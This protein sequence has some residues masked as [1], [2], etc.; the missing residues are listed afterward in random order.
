[1]NGYPMKTLILKWLIPSTL[2][3]ALL[4]ISASPCGA[5]II[6]QKG[7][8]DAPIRGYLVSEDANRIIVNQVLPDGRLRRVIL[9]R[10][11]IDETL[12]IVSVDP[13]RLARL[14]ADD[15]AGYRDYAEV[16]S[17]RR[18]DPD[19]Q[20]SAIRLY[21]IAAYLSPEKLGRGSLLGMARLARTPHEER[22]F[23]AFAYLLDPN[24][25][26][27]AMTEPEAVTPAADTAPHAEQRDRLL[28]GLRTLRGGRKAAA[29]N[30]ASAPLFRQ[31]LERYQGYIS[32]DEFLAEARKSNPAISASLLKRLV[33]LEL[34]LLQAE[35]NGRTPRSTTG[36]WSQI[37]A[38]QL[39]Q[40]VLPLTL[41][42]ITEFDPRK[43]MYQDGK[44][45]EP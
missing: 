35:P 24:H 3:L 44:W 30:W 18:K 23:R 15:P 36:P 20:V 22:A 6:F 42:T 43:W 2:V 40:P 1:M 4:L 33:T 39:Q 21:L 27:S 38:P 11:A 17:A 10:T 29:Q 25:D 8:E 31:A 9:P 19:A 7:K 13:K 26:R 41:E 14:H 16:L 5:V 34:V 45:V 12:T 37:P 32:Y 28:K